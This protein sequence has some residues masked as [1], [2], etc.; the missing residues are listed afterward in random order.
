MPRRAVEEL[1]D[2]VD[3]EQTCSYGR[4][5][6]CGRHDSG[7]LLRMKEAADMRLRDAAKLLIAR[8]ERAEK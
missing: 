1:G 6:E 2:R 4:L 7:D 3:I 8:F 5:S